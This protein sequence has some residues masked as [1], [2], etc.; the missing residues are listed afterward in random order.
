LGLRDKV[1]G[2]WRKLYN[3]KIS[4]LHLSPNIIWM[5]KSRIMRCMGHVACMGERIGAYWVLVG[6]GIR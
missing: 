4:D 3:E 1:T 6:P 2:D 5:I